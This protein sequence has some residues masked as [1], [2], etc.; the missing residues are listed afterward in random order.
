MRDKGKV[1]GVRDKEQG[2]RG[3]GTRMDMDKGKNNEG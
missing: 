3:K 1:W 2:V